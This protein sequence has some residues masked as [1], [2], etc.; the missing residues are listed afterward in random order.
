MLNLKT[1]ENAFTVAC[2]GNKKSKFSLLRPGRVT[3]Q[4]YRALVLSASC[5]VSLVMSVT[6]SHYIIVLW[7]EGEAE[8]VSKTFL[9]TRVWW[10]MCV[11][12]MPS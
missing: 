2:R 5:P 6:L 7:E 4:C 1:S 3:Q 12:A 9:H 8:E 11:P 10:G